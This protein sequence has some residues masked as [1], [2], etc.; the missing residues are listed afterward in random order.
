MANY[1]NADPELSGDLVVLE[2]RD[3]TKEQARKIADQVRR[4]K[5]DLRSHL[6]LLGYYSKTQF[7]TRS[8]RDARSRQVL[9]M[10]ENRPDHRITGGPWCHQ[11]YPPFTD[12]AAVAKARAL[13]LRHIETHSNEP[14]VLANAAHFFRQNDEQEMA[15]SL[16]NRAKQIDPTNPEWPRQLSAFYS[17]RRIL[18]TEDE[19]TR[20]AQ[21]ALLETELASK[22]EKDPRS[23]LRYLPDL[24]WLAYESGDFNKATRYASSVLKALQKLPTDEPHGPLCKPAHHAHLVLGSI[25]LSAGEISSSINHLML[26]VT[27]PKVSPGYG[28]IPE[29]SLAK[30]LLDIGHCD[31]VLEFLRSSLD[32]CDNTREREKR[33]LWI[34][35]LES[36]AIPALEPFLDYRDA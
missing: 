1:H 15:E 21:K 29:M 25:A 23:R 10:I 35:T 22:L 20:F 14:R 34:A 18:A 6:L 31:A 26:S 4:G 9:W 16:H 17:L 24:A 11:H 32:I 27:E 19:K 28:L 33:R 36:G 7:R 3:L 5:S 12:D 13:W 8:A 2:G 30:R